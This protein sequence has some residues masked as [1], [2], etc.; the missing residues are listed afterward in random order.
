MRNAKVTDLPVWRRWATPAL[1]GLCIFA[2]STLWGEEEGGGE[3]DAV[4]ALQSFDS[5]TSLEDGQPGDPGSWELAVP[6]GY[7][8][9]DEVKRAFG[10]EPEIKYT[11]DGDSDL[12]RG[13]K[14]SIAFEIEHAVEENP[15][16][17]SH[18]DF[19]LLEQGRLAGGGTLSTNDLLAYQLGRHYVESLY[20]EDLRAPGYYALGQR[21]AGQ[22]AAPG[23]LQQLFE[24]PYPITGTD[25]LLRYQ[26]QRWLSNADTADSLIE[27]DQPDFE[28]DTVSDETSVNLGW[29]QRWIADGGESSFRPTISTVSELSLPLSERAD[30]GQ[31]GTVTL[32]LSKFVGP[33]SV[34]LNLAG[35]SVFGNADRDLKSAYAVER[36]GYQWN[37]SGDEFTIIVGLA[38]EESD[39]RGQPGATTAEIAFKWITAGDIAI[40]PGLFFGVDGRETTPKFGVGL[41]LTF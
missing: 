13:T 30:R 3:E 28:Q 10:T 32:V 17:F 41:T 4:A 7:F 22:S 18:S 21:L 29:S 5:F 20:P 35:S 14:F 34:Y 2:A 23:S 6:L 1:I 19:V 16:A 33:G 25:D 36:I 40:G 12:S 15:R 11:L 8:E 9:S 37:V 27:S 26:L 39:E 38:H 31:T 24:A